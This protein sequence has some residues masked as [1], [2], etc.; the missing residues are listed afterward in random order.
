MLICFE[1]GDGVMG[2][3][4]NVPN[5]RVPSKKEIEERK[6]ALAKAKKELAQAESESKLTDKLKNE[7]KDVQKETEN[8]LKTG[9]LDGDA[10]AVAGVCDSVRALKTAEEKAEVV[11]EKV[12]IVQDEVKVAQE[13]MEAL[14]EK[15][16]TGA[17]KE[18]DLETALKGL[19]K[20]CKELQENYVVLKK[21]NDRLEQ[22][23]KDVEESRK[24]ATEKRLSK[25]WENTGKLEKQCDKL[26]SELKKKQEDFKDFRAKYGDNPAVKQASDK[27]EKALKKASVMVGNAVGLYEKLKKQIQSLNGGEVPKGLSK[28]V[29]EVEKAVVDAAGEVGGLVPPPPPPPPAQLSAEDKVLNELEQRLNSVART[30]WNSRDYFGCNM[31]KVIDHPDEVR[32]VAYQEFSDAVVRLKDKA[33]G[34]NTEEAKKQIIGQFTEL[35]NGMQKKVVRSITCVTQVMAD[36]TAVRERMLEL[37]GKVAKES[38]P[39]AEAICNAVAEFCSG[40]DGI[41]KKLQ[42]LG[43]CIIGCKKVAICIN[44]MKDALFADKKKVGI[45]AKQSVEFERAAFVRMLKSGLV[46]RDRDNTTDEQINAEY[47]KLK[48]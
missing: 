30:G 23:I 17:A 12:E 21:S 48:C 36:L 11:Q 43:K 42:S 20:K 10:A 1:K 14:Q 22:K 7:A 13:K 41:D 37:S 45:M 29:E 25:M 31:Q 19:R 3:D 26:S 32:N 35:K 47:E 18:E 2:N 15:A 8:D 40:S 4:R 28:I 9:V 5:F 33:D 6:A 46:W 16:E 27:M 24:V 44:G 38:H 39:N 34:A